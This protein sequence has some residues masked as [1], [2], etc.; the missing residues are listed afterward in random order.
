MKKTVTE[1]LTNFNH[2]NEMNDSEEEDTLVNVDDNNSNDVNDVH[3]F[4][5]ISATETITEETELEN[6]FTTEKR[7]LLKEKRPTKKIK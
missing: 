3:D 4:S 5:H 6:T 7:K 1:G 2:T